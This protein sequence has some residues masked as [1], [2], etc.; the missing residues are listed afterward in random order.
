MIS[1]L[2]LGTARLLKNLLQKHALRQYF[3]I[4]R[5]HM[6]KSADTMPAA[7]PVLRLQMEFACLVL[8]R[9]SASVVFMAK[10]VIKDAPIHAL[11]LL[12]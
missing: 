8:T 10:N 11:N 7:S 6:E 1:V 12:W 4:L 5:R 2:V 3:P 9:N